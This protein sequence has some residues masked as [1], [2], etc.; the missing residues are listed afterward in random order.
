[1]QVDGKWS[2]AQAWLGQLLRNY[3]VANATGLVECPLFHGWSQNFGRHNHGSSYFNDPWSGYYQLGMCARLW[4]PLVYLLELL[5]CPRCPV[6]GSAPR[7]AA[8][9]PRLALGVFCVRW[10]GTDRAARCYPTNE[11]VGVFKHV[12][13]AAGRAW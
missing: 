12:W 4:V 11:R 7:D 13:H 3:L 10:T 6:L 9:P 2:Y 5:L 8:D 1:M